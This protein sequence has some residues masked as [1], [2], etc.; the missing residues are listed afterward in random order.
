[1]RDE[2]EYKP[3]DAL[4]RECEEYEEDNVME[5]YGCGWMG[6]EY[7]IIREFGMNFYLC[8]ECGRECV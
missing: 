6:S 3:D 5:C 1:M 7:I 4:N 2:E 8:P